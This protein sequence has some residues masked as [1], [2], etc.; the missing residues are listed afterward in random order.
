MPGLCPIATAYHTR[1][2]GVVGP[3]VAGFG[4]RS[5]VVD[6][7]GGSGVVGHGGGSGCGERG[8]GPGT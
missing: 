1:G 3:A 6:H 4:V 5:T 2:G 8:R 7:G